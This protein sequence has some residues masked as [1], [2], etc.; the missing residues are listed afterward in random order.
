MASS[1]LLLLEVEV[2]DSLDGVYV[3]GIDGEY[4]LVFFDGL[5]GIA[6]VFG[7][8]RAGNVLLGV[9]GGEIDAGVEEAGIK[10][11]GSLEV[12]DGLFVAGVLVGLH[13]LVEVVAGL[14]LGAAGRGQ[15]DESEEQSSQHA[16]DSVHV[17]SPSDANYGRGIRS[18]E[19]LRRYTA[20][21]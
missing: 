9:S 11:D 13:T 16:Y 5:I 18:R 19:K 8:F 1:K 14:E 12:F 15:Y 17:M 7:G 10:A 3:A 2:G 6:L 20:T 4:L 21:A